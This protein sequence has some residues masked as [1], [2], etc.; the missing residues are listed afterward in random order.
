MPV[1]RRPTSDSRMICALYL[2]LRHAPLT[3]RGGPQLPRAFFARN[4]FS[5]DER[6]KDTAGP[7]G[8]TCGI[9]EPSGPG[10]HEMQSC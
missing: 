8:R 7:P 1:L 3:A 4:I 10:G 2:K 6:D 9:D 5:R